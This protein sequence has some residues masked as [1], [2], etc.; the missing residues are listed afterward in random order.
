M[1]PQRG[2]SDTRGMLS[3]VA[4]RL[5]LLAFA[6]AALAVLALPAAAAAKP[7]DRNHDR[8]PDRWEKRYGLS[9]KKRST[10]RKD[11]DR[12]H[13]N[14]L[15]EYRSGTNPLR[16]DTDRDGISDA[17]E[18]PDHDGVDNG[19]EAREHTSP[20]RRDT[21]RNGRPDGQE[22][23]D[24]DHLSNA[25]EDAAND[26]PIDPDTDDDGTQD[27]A[28]GAGKVEAFDGST[29]TL[30]L[31]AGG[32]VTAAV[33]DA[34]YIRCAGE[35]DEGWGDDI[36]GDGADDTSADDA[37]DASADDPAGALDPG[38]ADPGDDPADDAGDEGD[39]ASDSACGVGDLK[40]G[41]VV[42]SASVEIGPDGSFFD[43]LEIAR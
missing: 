10:A 23:P 27:G 20:R 18:D 21:N 32:S 39:D 17:N 29:L 37:D 8:I 2:R 41:A 14:N 3:H 12:D 13:L 11:N 36:P 22:D 40:V 35:P 38:A 33:D 9:T 15:A 4:R 6:L 16:A 1:D 5:R 43:E 26:D 30:R 7:R 31:F 25:G 19:N 24:R 28:E 42:R 34:T